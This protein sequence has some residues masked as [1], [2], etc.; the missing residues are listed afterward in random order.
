MYRSLAFFFHKAADAVHGNNDN[1]LPNP[2]VF[3]TDC[4]G[5]LQNG[6]IVALCINGQVTHRVMMNNITLIM[7]FWYEFKKSTGNSKQK[8]QSTFNA[9]HVFEHIFPSTI[10]AC[11]CHVCRVFKDWITGRDRKP[12]V[13]GLGERYVSMIAHV[14]DHVMS[15]ESIR[16]AMILMGRLIILLC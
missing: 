7:F 3:N 14:A 10:H 8:D 13:K 4:T 12:K 11:S 15:T 5:Q 2:I 6:C 1:P 9:Y 16:E